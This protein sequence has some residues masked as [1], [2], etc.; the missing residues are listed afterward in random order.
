MR[1]I[2]VF[3]LYASTLLAQPQID[4]VYPRVMPPDTIAYI[5][6]VDTN[7]IFG[8]VRPPNAV[9]TINGIKIELLS[10]GSFLAFLP[11]D[12]RSSSY[13]LTA[14]TTDDSSTLILPFTT[15]PKKGTSSPPKVTFPALITLSGGVARTNPDGAYYLFPD[16]GTQVIATD[17]KDNYYRVPISPYQSVWITSSYCKKIEE[18][19]TL[20][21]PVILKAYAEQ[22]N[23]WDELRV[24]IDHKILYHIKDES[25]PDKIV[26][27]FFGVISHLDRI[28]YRPGLKSIKE[29]IWSQPADEV[30]RLEVFL[31]RAPWGYKIDWSEDGQFIL[32]IKN[33]PDLD[34]GIKGLHIAIDPGHGGK[35][36]GAIGP[37][38]L[39]EREINLKVAEAVAKLLKNKSAR[40]TMTR[41]DNS[42]IGL[43]QRIR[44]A[45][46]A[47]A[48]VLISLHH[49]ALPDGTN[50]FENYGTGTHYY[51]PLSRD[52]ALSVHSELVKALML[53]DEGVYYNNLALVR[54]TSMPS[55]LIESAYIMFPDHEMMMLEDDYPAKIAKAIYIGI[56]EFVSSRKR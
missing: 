35:L 24:P 37:N 3:L 54:P 31:Q 8:S 16:E 18:R 36:D 47:G 9:L 41:T 17:W 4:V 50:P 32:H 20:P 56:N 39:T 10:N 43:T 38:R 55:I 48:D 46:D 12:W 1:S 5:D 6:G 21:V 51:H 7:F 45:E 34:S 27:D 28:A 25:E 42:D 11:V 40:V 52:F 15:R 13:H 44:I 19:K 23:G 26:V 22:S 2:L 49:N 29:V 33:P 53:P 14:K 30:V